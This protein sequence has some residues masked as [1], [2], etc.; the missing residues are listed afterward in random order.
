MELF[1]TYCFEKTITRIASTGNIFFRSGTAFLVRVLVEMYHQLTS[2][3]V[4]AKLHILRKDITR[5]GKAIRIAENKHWLVGLTTVFSNNIKSVVIATS[6]AVVILGLFGTSF[7]SDDIY[8]TAESYVDVQVN[9][10]DT[11]WS[12]A[13]RYASDKEDIRDLII[14]IKRINGL[15][16]N[17]LIY[18]G[19]V[20][21]IPIAA[22]SGQERFHSSEKNQ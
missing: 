11:V 15:N 18:P 13:A 14:A 16:N 9:Q 20:L 7:G 12:I 2:G 1:N 8:T 17:E 3:T 19:Q 5:T 6:V 10:G 21:K 4:L 22:K